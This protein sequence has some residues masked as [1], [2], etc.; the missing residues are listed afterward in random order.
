MSFVCV[1]Y[2]SLAAF[3]A[4]VRVGGAVVMSCLDVVRLMCV[5]MSRWMR[6]FA[7]I[8]FGEAVVVKVVFC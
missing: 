7:S 6:L 3:V 1:L 5:R 4:Q 2:V 8:C